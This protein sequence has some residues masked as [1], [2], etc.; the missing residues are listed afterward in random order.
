MVENARAQ[1]I[2]GK[3][4]LLAPLGVGGM[5]EVWEARHVVTGRH[6][7]VKLLKPDTKR[8]DEASRRFLREAQAI[9]RLEHPHVVE[10]LDAGIDPSS[11]APYIVQ[12]LLRGLSLRK[13]LRTRERLSPDLAATLVAPILRA[14]A[15]AHV[16]GIVHRD[17]KPT[18]V[19]L[20]R[21]DDEPL[22]VVTPK[23][24]DFGISKLE[25]RS[26]HTESLS[27]LTITGVV[28][29]TL[30]YMSP[31]QAEGR[32]DVDGRA[33]LW[34]VGVMLYEMVSGRRPFDAPSTAMMLLRIVSHDPPPLEGLGLDVP[35][36]FSEVVSRA[37]ARK[38]EER[39]TSALE[40]LEALESA[41]GRSL[42]DASIVVPGAS[43]AAA[44]PDDEAALLASIA[45][46]EA[47]ASTS[48]GRQAHSRAVDSSARSEA[49]A[50][51]PSSIP[52]LLAM[53][54][55]SAAAVGVIYTLAS[56][57]PS[58]D[59]PDAVVTAASDAAL[60]GDASVG[61]DAGDTTRDAGTDTL[62]LDAP[63][64]DVPERDVQAT[65]A[66][67]S[68]A[69]RADAGARAATTGT[70]GVPILSAE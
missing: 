59:A 68:R 50:R 25:E 23:I 32:D 13:Y 10:V 61:H 48:P 54:V 15:A 46:R 4:E 26:D 56:S 64:P 28:V 67:P 12:T 27:T 35:P 9:G 49:S 29:G 31:E 65:R 38:P 5:G 21:R 66:D 18:N 58:E 69:R 47:T 33:D 70:S 7:A 19:F 16:A 6:V 57:G 42:R 8:R 41:I 55:L 17:I 20:C 14:L 11:D 36:A 1:T 39:F 2:D 53:A 52:V 51:G 40:L 43:E 45:P 44:K 37:L 22:D 24:I 62:E 60:P 63:L 3:Y 34:A 30:G